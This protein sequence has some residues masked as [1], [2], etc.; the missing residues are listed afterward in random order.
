MKQKQTNRAFYEEKLNLIIEHIHN[1]LDSKIDIKMLAEISNFSPFHFHR[2]S[3]A[4]LGEPIGAYISRTRLETAA[5]MIRY[6]SL[7]MEAIA[8]HV[9]FETPSSLSKA[10]KI[11]FGVSPTTYRKTKVFTFKKKNIMTTTLN[12]KKPK[13][14]DIENMQCLYYRMQGAYQTL[15]YAG[16]WEKLW[17]QV[18][19]QK[20]FTKG[21][22]H[23]GLPHDDPKVTDE[24]KIRYDACLIIHKEAKPTGDIGVK[25]IRGGKFAVFL[26]QG[27][28]TYFANVY[29]YIFN[30]WLLNNDYELRDAPVRERYISHPDRVTED[31]LK[32]EFYIP[33]K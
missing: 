17:Q 7:G 30:E 27:S 16:A 3:R 23:I 9:G 13:I 19:E 4:L 15:D 33:I 28:Y 2:I 21:I 14:S 26:Y 29:D 22:Q 31:K 20:L 32:T 6:S 11:Q 18:K 25:T 5:K 12:I 24:H 10:F 8:Y 1:N